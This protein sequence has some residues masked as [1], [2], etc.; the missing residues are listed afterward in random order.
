MF[1]SHPKVG[2]NY[3]SC[4]PTHSAGLRQ[5]SRGRR[6]ISSSSSS[7]TPTAQCGSQRH[8]GEVWHPVLQTE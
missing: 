7:A 8:Y 1:N 4:K 5:G 2:L 3:D 6:S